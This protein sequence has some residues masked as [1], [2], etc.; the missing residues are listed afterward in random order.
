MPEKP[1]HNRRRFLR[2]ASLTVAAAEFGMIGFADAQFKE[3]PL[4]LKG[5]QLMSQPAQ[6]QYTSKPKPCVPSALTYRRRPSSTFAGASQ[7]HG[8]RTERR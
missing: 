3:Q 8:G 5:E 6:A 7:R 1:K 2:N 4:G